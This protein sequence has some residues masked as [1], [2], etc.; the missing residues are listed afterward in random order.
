[1]TLTNLLK[2]GGYT[3]AIIDTCVC[4]ENL[5]ATDPA[6]DDYLGLLVNFGGVQKVPLEPTEIWWNDRSCQVGSYQ[7]GSDPGQPQDRSTGYHL[8]TRPG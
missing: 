6:A 1:M 3:F 8:R 4:T 7:V 5:K 2:L